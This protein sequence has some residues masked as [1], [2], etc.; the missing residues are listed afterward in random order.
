MR[1]SALTMAKVA[2]TFAMLVGFATIVLAAPPE[3]PTSP[4]PSLPKSRQYGI[5]DESL[6]RQ[7]LLAHPDDP[8]LYKECG[9]AL[10]RGGRP[11]AAA[12][13]YERAVLLRSKDASLRYLLAH[14]YATYWDPRALAHAATAIE[15]DP[16]SADALALYG[17]L[18]RREGRSDEAREFLHKAWTM[19][20]P[21]IAAGKALARWETERDRHDEAARI[22]QVCAI[23]KPN[24]LEIQQLL[25]SSLERSGDLRGAARIYSELCR[26]G[27][28]GALALA[29]LGDLS[30]YLDAPPAQE[31]YI[32][33]A[34]RIDPTVRA[35]SPDVVSRV[36]SVDYEYPSLK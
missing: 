27:E 4:K 36:S 6:L 18:L 9:F 22:L 19:S 7:E 17:I 24:D 1:P 29:R 12:I 3:L 2:G 26:K 14:A 11:R 21:S 20:P 10:H 28:G 30:G 8:E 35:H 31:Q 16:S 23:H 13:L 32:E 25:A 34:Q 15:L 5:L 33:A